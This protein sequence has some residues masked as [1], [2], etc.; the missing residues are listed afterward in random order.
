MSKL[1]Y[2]V[3][4]RELRSEAEDDAHD[5]VEPQQEE[6]VQQHCFTTGRMRDIRARGRDM[7]VGIPISRDELKWIEPVLDFWTGI[8]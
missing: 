8:P 2:I 1:Q 3:W 7:V 6:L 5:D 4:G